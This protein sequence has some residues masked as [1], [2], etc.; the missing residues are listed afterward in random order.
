MEKQKLDD[1]P[2]RQKV[3]NTQQLE[4]DHELLQY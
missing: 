2:A 4:Q 1:Y 3:D